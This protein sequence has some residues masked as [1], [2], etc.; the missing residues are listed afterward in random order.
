MDS[1]TVMIVDRLTF[2]RAGLREVLSGQADFELI[3]CHPDDDVLGLIAAGRP[4]VVLLDI[5]YPSIRTFDLSR[6][7]A[8]YYPA[9]RVIMLSSNTGDEQLFEAVK[10]GAVAYL[11][12]NTHVTEL[13]ETIG[14]VYS[15]EHPINENL[16][17]SPRVAKHVL[18][19]FRTVAS[20]ENTLEG[21]VAGLTPRET[22]VL[23]HIAT[24]NSNK[25]IA[26]V[27][28]ISEQTIKNHVSAI[29]DRLHANDRAHAVVLAIRRGWFPIEEEV[30]SLAYA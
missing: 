16:I 1:I 11:D 8:R 7:I 23:N 10:T 28:G 15:G 27:L 21:I 6:E 26:N 25:Q 4:D 17:A 22:Q 12:K 5:E 20:A 3:D 19:R 18:R 30:V 14:R 29:L 24:G 2:F 9:I 13:I